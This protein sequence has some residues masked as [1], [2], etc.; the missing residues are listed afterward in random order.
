MLHSEGKIMDLVDP[1]MSLDTEEEMQVQ[2]V[3]DVAL[4]CL[5]ANPDRR[6]TMARVVAMLQGD[7]KL[8]AK[9]G[10]LH[11]SFTFHGNHDN[12]DESLDSLSISN[13][14]EISARL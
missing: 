11:R 12:S 6:P 10:S 2:C 8:E 5:D 4:L 14:H 9:T 13:S 7:T 1:T 3:F